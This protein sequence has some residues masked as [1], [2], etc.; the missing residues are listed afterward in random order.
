ME[1]NKG[2]FVHMFMSSLVIIILCFIIM[3]TIIVGGNDDFSPYKRYEKEIDVNITS[4]SSC[5]DDI[6]DEVTRIAQ[7][8][9]NGAKLTNDI[10][11]L[12][13]SKQINHSMGMILFDYYKANITEN[14][15]TKVLLRYNILTSKVDRVKIEQ[16]YFE[17]FPNNELL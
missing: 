10:I 7:K 5:I 9:Q 17:R 14:Q 2:G 13:G 16:G 12:D 6:V 11:I 4:Y 3:I 8:Y 15:I 1:K